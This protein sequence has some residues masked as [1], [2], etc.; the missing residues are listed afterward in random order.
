MPAEYRWSRGAACG[1]SVPPKEMPRKGELGHVDVFTGAKVVNDRRSRG[2]PIGDEANVVIPAYCGL[3]GPF[4][5]H[6]VDA[7]FWNLGAGGVLQFFLRSIVAT[8]SQ[9][10]RGLAITSSGL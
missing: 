6:T 10:C 3:A 7:A 1:A 2:P 4:V 9:D 8:A 5:S